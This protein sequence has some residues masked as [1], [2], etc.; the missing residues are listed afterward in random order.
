VGGGPVNFETHKRSKGH[1]TNSAKAARNNGPRITNFFGPP[2]IVPTLTF[3]GPRPPIA[4]PEPVL[5]PE[6]ST[7]R[8]SNLTNA[9]IIDVNVIVGSFPIPSQF[10][11]SSKSLPSI[12]GTPLVPNMLLSQLQTLTKNLP[13]SIPLSTIAE[14]LTSFAVNP[15]DLVED[16]KDAWETVVD[17]TFNRVI[18]FGVTTAQIAG[19][20]RRGPYGMDG[21]CSWTESCFQTLNIALSLLE[22]Q[23][24]RI[25]L[26][27]INLYVYLIF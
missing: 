20:I 4:T 26:A 13:T 24:E 8:V 19:F 12:G 15:K 1:K 16:R 21:F 22:G 25:M 17:P 7:S 27:M 2:K 14:P 11:D 18:G 5:L 9:N 23:I 3:P 6:A 10:L